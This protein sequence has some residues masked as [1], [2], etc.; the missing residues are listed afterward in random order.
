MELLL[1]VGLPQVHL[2]RWAGCAAFHS[3]QQALCATARGTE[4]RLISMALEVRRCLA[5]LQNLLGFTGAALHTARLPP[6]EEGGPARATRCHD[7]ILIHI[8]PCPTEI[9]VSVL[10]SVGPLRGLPL[11]C[12]TAA[13][14]AFTSRHWVGAGP[15]PGSCSRAFP[16]AH[17]PLDQR[18]Q[19]S[20]PHSESLLQF[21]LRHSAYCTALQAAKKVG[22]PQE[23]QRQDQRTGACPAPGTATP[24]LNISRRPLRHRS[25]AP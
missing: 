22:D 14:A 13:P 8:S 6:P 10:D 20:P 15:G 1:P 19:H 24:L 23:V 2:P 16:L 9:L 11:G 7:A 25:S 18:N 17:L 3:L 5:G 21:A 4:N 12:G